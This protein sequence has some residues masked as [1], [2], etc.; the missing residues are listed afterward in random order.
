MNAKGLSLL[1]TAVNLVLGILKFLIGLFYHSIALMAEG[2]HSSLD[3]VSSFVAFLGIKAAKKP[4]DKKHPYGRERYESLASLIIALL[5]A[6]SAFWILIE[7]GKNITSRQTAVLFPFWG[8]ILMLVSTGVNEIMARLKFSFGNKFSSLALVTDGEHSRA[9]ALSSLAMLF[10]LM[11]I[12]FFPMADSILAVLVAF[13][14][15][16]ETYHLSREAADSLLDVANPQLE[17]KIKEFLQKNAFKFS[18]IKT[19]K[20]G[21]NNFAEISLLFNPNEKI[22][23]IAEI[24]RRLEDKLLKEMP[25]LKQVSLL[26]KSHD[27]REGVVRPRFSGCFRFRKGLEKIGPEKKGK[28][29]VIPLEKSNIASELGT[30][31]YLIIDISGQGEILQKQKIRN[32]YFK[33]EGPGHGVRFIKSVSADVLIAKHIGENA[34]KNLEARGIKIKIANKNTKL[35]DLDYSDVF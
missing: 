19:R 3:V 27:F 25:E 21:L 12:K 5:L 4:A 26:V 1:S 7:A 20:V 29:I 9:D 2:L 32:P 8:I 33:T 35:E 6:V 31:F 34:K 16:Y 24:T 17:E 18:E 15:F 13:Y 23:R 22:D 10:G 28:R 14:I 30:P 11:L